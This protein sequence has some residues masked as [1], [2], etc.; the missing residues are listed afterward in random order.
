MA[1]SKE[2]IE[3]IKSSYTFEGETLLIGAGI[4][5]RYD[6]AGCPIRIPLKTLNR[7]G[8]IAGAT[9]TG[10]TKSLQVLAE[11]MSLAGIPVL[12]MDIK[13][14]MSGIAKPGSMNPNIEKRMNLLQSEWS[15]RGFPVE[16]LTISDEPGTRLR[17]TVSEFG[18]VLLAKILGL[19]DNQSGILS[20]IFKFCDER[21]LPLLDL[22]DLGEVLKFIQEEGREDFIRNY[23]QFQNAT[24][25][26]IL[27]KTIEL[28]QQGADKFFGEPSFE[29]SDLL[30]KNSEGNGFIN[31][32]RL[33]DMQNK[34]ALFSTFMLCLLA[35]VYEKFPEKGDTEIP[36][37][38]LF[39]DEAH[40]VFDQANKT[41]TDHLEM[42]IRL[43][44]SKGVGLIFVTQSP[45]D[46]PASILSQLGLKIQ[47]A[48]RAF[49]AKDRKA[50]KTAAENYPVSGFY[51]TDE[52]ITQLGI[53]EAL[54]TALDEMGRPTELVHTL[55]RPPY[56]RMGILSREEMSEQI[57]NS[58]IAGKYNETLD[59]E[60]A[61][62]LLN[63]KMARMNQ[64]EKHESVD[65]ETYSE[66]ERSKRQQGEADMF[67]EILRSPVTRTVVKELTR[68][69]FGVLGLS[70][71]TRRSSRRKNTFRF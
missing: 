35:E 27:R 19:N 45:D 69:L 60:S 47:H 21:H 67:G 9:G 33:T 14:D 43:I 34:P 25:G 15:G 24:T 58:D 71:T 44:R 31:I 18:P 29:V 65:T 28:G 64:P 56:S 66:P 53:G 26:I 6:N 57:R 50:I 12:L 55:M 5:N 38:I 46:I 51:K 62:E 11:S 41:L 61:Y 70:T 32:I 22:K 59:R 10:K 4:L 17:A 40:L 20:L 2:F 48:L 7:H 30:R 52:L 42:I 36:E 8:L 68:G 16:L 63:R 54:V 49:T 3:I 37:L 1:E 23:G 39:I 13:G